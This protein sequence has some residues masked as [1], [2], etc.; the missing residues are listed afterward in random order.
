MR[1]NS[2]I[3]TAAAILALSW[4]LLVGGKH[5]PGLV[6]DVEAEAGTVA[7]QLEGTWAVTVTPPAGGPPA[8]FSLGTYARGG[9]LITPPDP[10]VGPGVTS[11]GQGKWERTGDNQFVSTHVAFTY[12]AG[13]HITGTIRI[14]ASYQLTGKDSFEG[15]GQL[16][17]CDAS[18]NNCFTPPG[19]PAL[20]TLRGER[21]HAEPPSCPE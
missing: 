13:G 16:Q 8:Y 17:F 11:T 14:K 9:V 4:G 20:A 3:A 7:P 5:G 12:D 15:S 6:P 10:S 19:C 18:L 2:I 21:I 1:R